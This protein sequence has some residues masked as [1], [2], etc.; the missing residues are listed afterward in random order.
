MPACPSRIAAAACT[1]PIAARPPV[2]RAN[3]A[4]AS[5]NLR[6]ADALLVN[7]IDTAEPWAIDRVLAN[8]RRVNPG[9]L[10][11]RAAS[12]VTVD[13]PS[14]LAGRRVLAIEDG[15]TLTHGGATTGAAMIGARAA[16]AAAL[17]DPRPFLQGELVGTFVKY[18]DLGALLPA[19]GYGPSRSGTSKR[20][21]ARRP[22]E[23]WRR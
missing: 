5:T 22:R 2:L 11:I 8:V 13:D 7:K 21:C 10:V 15:P 18:P 4:A 20:R 19:M 17:V 3:S 9:A 1:G 16:G 23:A 6:L 12:P 14:V